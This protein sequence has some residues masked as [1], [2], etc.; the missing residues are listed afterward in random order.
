[1]ALVQL[2][3]GVWRVPTAPADSI[4]SVLPADDGSLTLVAASC[5]PGIGVSGRCT[6]AEPAE[7]PR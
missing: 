2:A 3:D 7:R 5:P 6:T 4:N 1:M